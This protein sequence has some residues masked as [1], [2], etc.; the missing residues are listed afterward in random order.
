[1]RHARHK[2]VLFGLL[3]ELGS[4]VVSQMGGDD[5][6]CKVNHG[7][8]KRVHDGAERV[9]R[10]RDADANAGG[11]HAERT[12][13]ERIANAGKRSHEADL[14]G[15]NRGRVEVLIGSRLLFHRNR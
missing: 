3:Q 13:V 15:V 7:V 4:Q 1:M 12:P 5:T 14:H 9:A 2:V 8:D 6:R 10:R 11:D